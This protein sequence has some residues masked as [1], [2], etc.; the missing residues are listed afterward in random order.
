MPDVDGA[1]A[2]RAI[3]EFESS[4]GLPP[5]YV[6]FYTADVTDRAYQLLFESGADEIMHK[7]PK[8]G[9]FAEL[10]ERLKVPAVPTGTK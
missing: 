6:L 1:A 9:S 2:T 8:K 3:R 4:E 7:P 10:V 5:S